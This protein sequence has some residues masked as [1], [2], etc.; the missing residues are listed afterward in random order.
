MPTVNLDNDYVIEPNSSG[1]W[2]RG[3]LAEIKNYYQINN[4]GYNSTIDYEALKEENLNIAIIGDSYIQGF[5]TDVRKSIGRQLEG[6]LDSV[7]T[8]VHE[9]G[10]AG[11]NIVD[12]QK[13]YEKYIDSKPYD[14]V[15]VLVTDKDLKI[16]KASYM[17]RGKSVPKKTFSRK[18]YDFFY[19]FRY[20]NINQGI[21]IRFNELI[22]KGPE[23]IER[24]HSKQSKST[25]IEDY[26]KSINK[27]AIDKLPNNLIFLYEEGKLSDYFIDNFDFNYV[28]IEH[29]LEP[30]NHGFDGHWNVNGRYNCAMSIAKYINKNSK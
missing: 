1:T 21:G 5:Q 27:Q 6:I 2:I 14:Y 12:Y 8:V 4:L 10:R 17:E 20:L 9:Y 23:S 28:K 16:F 22:S 15:F 19:V 29:T 11:A 24:I 18:M 13:V 26:L 30:S 3:G 25:T 7:T